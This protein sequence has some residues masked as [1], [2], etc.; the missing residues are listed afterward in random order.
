[1]KDTSGPTPQ[2]RMLKEMSLIFRA[3]P[4]PDDS[5]LGGR[6]SS[7]FRVRHRIGLPGDRGWR[8]LATPRKANS[9]LPWCMELLVRF[10]KADVASPLRFRGCKPMQRLALSPAANSRAKLAS[11]RLAI[12][13]KRKPAARRLARHEV[14][15][16]RVARGLRVPRLRVGGRAVFEDQRRVRRDRV[17]F[18][19]AALSNC[20]VMFA[21]G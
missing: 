3:S 5:I 20:A 21:R 8:S 11:S 19:K 7:K 13:T 17:A 15:R 18:T 2:A 12:G 10:L 1:M 9:T 16:C 14:Q 4:L 6:G